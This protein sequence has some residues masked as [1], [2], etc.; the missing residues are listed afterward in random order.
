MVAI[1]QLFLLF[2]VAL[3]SEVLFVFGNCLA[4]CE[5]DLDIVRMFS[6]RYLAAILAMWVLCGRYWGVMLLLF[7]V[8]GVIWALF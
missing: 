8:L 2:G 4:V 1:W 5:S 7:S 3:V 6:C